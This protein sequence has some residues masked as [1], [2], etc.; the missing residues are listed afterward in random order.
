MGY[1]GCSFEIELAHFEYN[2]DAISMPAD[3]M[4]HSIMDDDKFKLKMH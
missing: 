4:D 3:V 2:F 1:F